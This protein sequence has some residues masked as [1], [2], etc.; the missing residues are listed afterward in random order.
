MFVREGRWEGETRKWER[1]ISRFPPVCSPTRDRIHNL[2]MYPDQESNLQR[3]SAQDNIPISWT[4]W[5]VLCL[6]SW[7][8]A[9]NTHNTS[10]GDFESMFIKAGNSE[11]KEGL[12]VEDAG[13]ESL[14]GALLWLSRNTVEKKW[15]K[16]RL[17]LVHWKVRERSLGD[18]FRGWVQD[19]LLLPIAPL[20]VSLLGILSV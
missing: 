7:L 18:G 13:R 19:E 9:G 4:T 8:C 17:L 3:F 5:P 15:A 10:P 6:N 20:V 14:G 1:N 12:R 2:G 16:E 11:T